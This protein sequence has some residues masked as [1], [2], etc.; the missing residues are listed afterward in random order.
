MTNRGIFAKLGCSRQMSMI[1]E[2]ISI[3]YRQVKEWFEQAQA[4]QFES[5]R[6]AMDNDYIIQVLSFCFLDNTLD[7]SHPLFQ[8]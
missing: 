1:S 5:K 7:S 3:L 8:A 2:I 6:A 4:I